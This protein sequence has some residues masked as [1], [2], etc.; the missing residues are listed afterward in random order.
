MYTSMEEWFHHAE[1]KNLPLWKALQLN[2]CRESDISEAASFEKMHKLYKDMIRS[3]TEYEPAARSA[4]GLVGG[5]AELLHQYRQEGKSMLGDFLGAVMERALRIA[6]SNACM[7]VI[8]ATPTAGSCGILP[9]VLISAQQYFENSDD[10]ITQALYVAAGVGGV[11]AQRASISGAAGGCQAEIGSAAAM[12][13]A[14]LVYLRKGTGRQCA[15]AAAIALKGMLGLV[16]DP[17]CGLVEVPCV[18]RNVIGAVNAVSSAEMSL[19]GIRSQI[20][21]DQVF[22]AMGRIGRQMPAALRE[23]ALGGLATTPAAEEIAR[24]LKRKL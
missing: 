11:I 24:R 5:E 23:T 16:C 8:V 2:D 10:E 22:D 6:A 17:V 4:S 14:A 12:A 3:D 13:G 9:A 15:E 7:H 19:A 1:Q 20:P 21:A 18:K